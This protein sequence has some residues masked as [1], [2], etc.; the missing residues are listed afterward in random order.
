MCIELAWCTHRACCRYAPVMETSLTYRQIGVQMLFL[1]SFT[2]QA[3][4]CS[5][6]LMLCMHACMHAFKSCSAEPPAPPSLDCLQYRGA[7]GRA[8][9]QRWAARAT[10]GAAG[11]RRVSV[12]FNTDTGPARGP[13]PGAISD[14]RELA[15][16][17]RR[18]GTWPD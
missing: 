7:H 5:R 15:A 3:V 17:L 16:A 11:G 18:N 9:M 13:R 4:P 14:C 10:Q 2:G 12:A 1:L 8:E 6:I